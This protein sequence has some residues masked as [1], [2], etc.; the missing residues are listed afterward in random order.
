MLRKKTMTCDV[1]IRT[2]ALFKGRAPT[3]KFSG[4]R[5]EFNS[6]CNKQN[7]DLWPRAGVAG[8]GEGGGRWTIS[9]R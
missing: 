6:R 1:W 5:Q 8:E 3:M 2:K 9:K 4:E 7:R